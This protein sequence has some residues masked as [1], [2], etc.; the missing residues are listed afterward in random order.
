[1]NPLAAIALGIGVYFFIQN[2]KANIPNGT[3][4]DLNQERQA[5][6]NWINSGGDSYETKQRF[7]NMVNN[8]FTASELDAVYQYVF[9]YLS[10]GVQ[11]TSSNPLYYQIQAISSKY[12]IFT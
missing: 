8:V 4:I 12:N 1:M 11:L 2:R 9:N 5:L 6:I 3:K 7:A 10:T